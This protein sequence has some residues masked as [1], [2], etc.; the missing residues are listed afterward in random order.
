MGRR[1]G[2]QYRPNDGSLLVTTNNK[3]GTVNSGGGGDFHAGIGA[4][5]TP[6]LQ[7]PAQ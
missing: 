6:L 4:H 1:E 7:P 3:H 2:E 5:G